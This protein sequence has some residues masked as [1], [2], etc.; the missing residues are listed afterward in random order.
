MNKLFGSLHVVS[1]NLRLSEFSLKKQILQVV[2]QLLAF[3]VADFQT[4]GM[5]LCPWFETSQKMYL[6]DHTFKNSSFL[7]I[8]KKKK[9]CYQNFLI[10]KSSHLFFFS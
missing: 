8:S 3:L 9:K 7:S 6:P 4:V 5:V 2:K 10:H 1:K